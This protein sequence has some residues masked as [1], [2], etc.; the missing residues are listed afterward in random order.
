MKSLLKFLGLAAVIVLAGLWIMTVSKSCNKSNL[1]GT[2][3]LETSASDKITEVKDDTES[4]FEGEPEE[5]GLFNEE[6]G[7]PST[8]G[9]EDEDDHD[10]DHDEGDYEGDDSDLKAEIAA[11]QKAGNSAGSGSASTAASSNLGMEYL[12]IGGAYI[13]EVNAKAEVKRLKKKGYSNAEVVTFDFSQYHSVCVKRTS[14]RSDAR[15]IKNKLVKD[16]NSEAY[17]HKKR[18]YLNKN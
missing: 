9:D 6:G 17:V 1:A 14:S 11:R 8:S 15:A 2:T 13:A 7:E 18:R 16:G 5:E 10:E 3:K 12:V 4:L